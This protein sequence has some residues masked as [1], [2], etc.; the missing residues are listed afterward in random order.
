MK[1]FITCT[2]L[3]LILSALASFVIGANPSVPFTSFHA[4]LVG[5]FIG[6][7]IG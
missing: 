6:Y 5:G 1:K 3:A 2:A 4:L 7:A